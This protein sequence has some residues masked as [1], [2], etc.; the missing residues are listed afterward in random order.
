M[1]AAV[2]IGGDPGV[3]SGASTLDQVGTAAE[4]HQQQGGHPPPGE[5][6]VVGPE[7]E[8]AFRAGVRRHRPLLATG[9]LCQKVIEFGLAGA[10][11]HHVAGRA[12]GLKDVEG[13]VGRHPLEWDRGIGAEVF[14]S[15]QAALLGGP[16]GEQHRAFGTPLTGQQPRHLQD[17][18]HPQGVVY[19][20]RSDAPAL[21]VRRAFTIGV[22][23]GGD[24]HRLIRSATARQAGDDIVAVEPA[25][26]DANLGA[27]PHSLELDGAEVG[28]PGLFPQG[29]K[30]Q[31]CGREEAGGS[32]RRQPSL[33]GKPLGLGTRTGDVIALA[34]RGNHCGPAIARALGLVD[35][36]GG[37]RAP[38]YGFLELVGP[39]RIIGRGPPSELAGHRIRRRRL[40]VGIID[41]ENGDLAAQVDALVVIPAALRCRDAVADEDHGRVLH[42]D[43][44]YRQE[45]N[46]R[47]V[48]P[49]SQDRLA[50]GPGDRE[51]AVRRQLGPDQGNGLEEASPWAGRLQAHLPEGGLKVGQGLR[52]ARPTRC[53]ASIGVRGQLPGDVRKPG[54]IRPVPR[55]CGR[56]REDAEQAAQDQGRQDQLGAE[57]QG[58]VP[59]SPDFARPGKA[60]RRATAPAL[61]RPGQGGPC[62]RTFRRRRRRW[63]PRRRPGPPPPRCWRPARP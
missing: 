34:G 37:D 54:G 8:G 15:Q 26:G 58:H 22:P 48:A 12:G 40:E 53:P 11:Q 50:L 4:A 30:I 18:R 31:A 14:G 9:R 3:A 19:G 47:D 59:Q 43:P 44:V 49:G 21:C 13:Q 36:Q 61:P 55:R 41:Q 38:S 7:E 60:L 5:A 27:E 10:H 62:R 39:T 63:E 35:D 6:E 16:Q 2:R 25:V 28:R 29:R 20:T 23:V 42:G 46:D 24:H 45:G 56:G 52:L 33:K 1:V 57:A 17:P 32:V 51:A